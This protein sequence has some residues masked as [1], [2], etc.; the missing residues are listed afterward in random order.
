VAEFGVAAAGRRDAPGVYVSGAKL[1]SVGLRIR[2]GASYHGVALNVSLDLEPFS[3]INVCGYRGLAVTRLVD[4]CAGVSAQ[5]GS[6]AP[7]GV[8][9]DMAQVIDVATPH[10]LRHLGFE[11]SFEPKLSS[12]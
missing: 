9:A 5:A 3:R 4:L 12:R 10:L 7:R 1:A 2:R 11:P 6:P 8:A